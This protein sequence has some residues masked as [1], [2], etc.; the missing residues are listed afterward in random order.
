MRKKQTESEL[1]RV[2]RKVR[3]LRPKG[4]RR[5]RLPEK[6]WEE[7]VGLRDLGIGAEEIVSATGLRHESVTKR[8]AL[9]RQPEVKSLMVDSGPMPVG[10]ARCELRL[11][12]GVS[13]LLP[14]ECL[15][16]E[17]LERILVC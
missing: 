17:L 5:T 1:R 6:L 11:P 13:L 7:I 8:L 12:S 16:G 14:T 2:A 10:D 3:A 15:T 4:K 9:A